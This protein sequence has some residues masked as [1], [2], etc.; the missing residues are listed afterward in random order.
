MLACCKRVFDGEMERRAV[1]KGVVDR[2]LNACHASQLLILRRFSPLTVQNVADYKYI[3][4]K[5]CTGHRV[6][7]AERSSE[8][9]CACTMSCCPRPA[10][11]NYPF[12]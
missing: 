6:Q 4:S 9:L 1:C 10:I 11:P 12:S 3:C 5:L 2:R 8:A 7:H